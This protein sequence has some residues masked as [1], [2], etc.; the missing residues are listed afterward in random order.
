MALRLGAPV[1]VHTPHKAGSIPQL[2]FSTD[3][4]MPSSSEEDGRMYA[5]PERFVI[6]FAIEAKSIMGLHH[7]VWKPA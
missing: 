5:V 4:L 1:A 2:K 6:G 3:S 7:L